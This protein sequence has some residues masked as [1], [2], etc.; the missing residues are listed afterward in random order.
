MNDLH[1]YR[2]DV[3][4]ENLTGG[5]GRGKGQPVGH[6]FEGRGSVPPDL[7]HR[8]PVLVKTLKP[9]FEIKNLNFIN[10]KHYQIC[11]SE[12][13]RNLNTFFAQFVTFI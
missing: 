4:D 9:N 13:S 6:V 12:N 5:V 7:Q 8:G 2:F 10:L 11:S 3:P 1:I